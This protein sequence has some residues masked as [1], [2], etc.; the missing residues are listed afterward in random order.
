M[1]QVFILTRLI[2]ACIVFCGGC[3]YSNECEATAAWVTS[4]G[5]PESSCTVISTLPFFANSCPTVPDGIACTADYNP[6]VSLR[7][8][9]ECHK[10]S[11]FSFDSNAFIS[12]LWQTCDNDCRYDNT[13]LAE[14]SGATGCTDSCPLPDAEI[15]CTK[16]Y[17]P[18]VCGGCTYSNACIGTA[19]GFAE[20]DC[21]TVCPDSSTAAEGVS[22]TLEY[23]PVFCQ[24]CEFANECV[25]TSLGFDVA[26]DCASIAT[27]QTTATD[28]PTDAP[29]SAANGTMQIVAA[30][31]AAFMLGTLL[32]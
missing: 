24:G 19:A 26:A 4:A 10:Y 8:S 12:V 23:A 5:L 2:A 6:Q 29:T 16:E 1:V 30:M 27:A 31:V 11:L 15:V 32:I 13:C 14:A 17:N 21:S 7:S 20:S 9:L 3:V 28:G 18:V 22:C 25:A